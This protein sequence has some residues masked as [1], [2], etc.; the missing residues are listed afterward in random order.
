MKF[1]WVVGR[2]PRTNCS[3]FGGHL[4]PRPYFAPFSPVMHFQWDIIS[5]LLYSLGGSSNLDKGYA[6]YRVPSSYNISCCVWL[7]VTAGEF[8]LIPEGILQFYCEAAIK[9]IF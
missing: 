7:K 8:L 9:L 4:D 1:V 5:L 2:G 6:L 3:D